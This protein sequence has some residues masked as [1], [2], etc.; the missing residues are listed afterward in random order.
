MLNS[1]YVFRRDVVSKE[2]DS[3]SN[4]NVFNFQFIHFVSVFNLEKESN[5]GLWSDQGVGIYL[6]DNKL[7]MSLEWM[8]I[9][10][11]LECCWC[12]IE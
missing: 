7:G 11:I 2:Q 3:F 12:A 4:E 5:N 10:S 6:A 1:K 9:W 8:K